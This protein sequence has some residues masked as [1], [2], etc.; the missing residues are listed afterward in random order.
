[1]NNDRG[2]WTSASGA[3]ADALCPG[4]HLAQFGLHS[5]RSEDSQHGDVIHK[6]L[7]DGTDAGLSFEQRETLAACKAIEQKVVSQFFGLEIP[8]WK[9]RER[10]FWVTFTV[11]ET[12]EL[13]HSGQ[14]DLAQRDGLGALIIDYKSLAGSIPESPKNLQ[15]R[16]LAVLVR[17]NLLVDHIG[18]C[19]VQP[20]VTHSPEICLYDRQSLMLAK[21]QMRERV[22]ASN[23]P[24]SKRTPGE[25]QCKFC[26]AAA[27]GTCVEYQQWAGQIAPPA[28][29]AALDVPIAQWSPET[30]GRAMDAVKQGYKLLETIEAAVR[31]GLATD[32]TFCPGWELAP[33]RNIE[34]IEEPEL[35]FQ[36]FIALGGKA[37]DFMSCVTV[38]KGQLRATLSNTL[39]TAIPITGK[40]LSEIFSDLLRG[41][42]DTSITQP[43]LKRKDKD[44]EK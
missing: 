12:I 37:E 34:T 27:R 24:N 11:G 29:M 43:I 28:I 35:V 13:R 23:N 15:L 44:A 20:F 41:C 10:R 26:L 7:C 8:S 4:R 36:R 25:L 30:R 9:A 1:M 2:N 14:V 22:I 5:E 33:G 19:V 40:A 18:V 17:E 39:S 21:E 16:D 3:P 42:T 31:E 38:R 6:A 32:P